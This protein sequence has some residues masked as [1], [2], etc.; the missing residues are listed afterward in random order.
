M[1]CGLFQFIQIAGWRA[2]RGG[3]TYYIHHSSLVY[4]FSLLN[5]LYSA[6]C[7]LLHYALVLTAGAFALYCMAH[8]CFLI[9]SAVVRT[10]LWPHLDQS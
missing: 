3:Y 8:F 5:L 4:P 7:P 1:R 10:D 2:G 9:P 6:F